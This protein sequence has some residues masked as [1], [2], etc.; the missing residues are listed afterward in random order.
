[1][2]VG[3]C[4]CVRL[5]AGVSLTTRRTEE[6]ES[7]DSAL[8]APLMND[9]TFVLVTAKNPEGR[10][11]A[12]N[13]AALVH[14]SATPALVGSYWETAPLE[15]EHSRNMIKKPRRESACGRTVR[16]AAW[17]DHNARPADD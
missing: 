1:M 9:P 7:R 2:G 14:L 8:R 16:A 17:E 13:N 6:E 5:R 3:V 10:A 15:T 11:T 12:P 4:V